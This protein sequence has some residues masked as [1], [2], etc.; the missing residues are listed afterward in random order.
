MVPTHVLFRNTASLTLFFPDT[1]AGRNARHLST[2]RILLLC[3]WKQR[4]PGAHE[5][6][7][8]RHAVQFLCAGMRLGV[9][10]QCALLADNAGVFDLKNK[11]VA[12]RVSS[13]ISREKNS[14]E[15]AGAQQAR[16][17]RC[18]AN[19]HAHWVHAQAWALRW[20]GS[21][22][23]KEENVST[24]SRAKCSLTY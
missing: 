8:H 15:G 5:H 6:G 1:V 14:Q 18:L 22:H 4:A 16:N 7:E 2:T 19:W 17:A 21:R 13:F 10:M 24:L 12:L 9:E 11:C 20:N 23:S 3:R